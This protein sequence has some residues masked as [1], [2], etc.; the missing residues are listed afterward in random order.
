MRL[1]QDHSTL[2]ALPLRKALAEF[3]YFDSS[4]F[5]P[6]DKINEQ[7]NEQKATRCFKML[8][9]VGIFEFLKCLVIYT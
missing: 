7:K 3:I 4:F 1:F 9:E 6:H 8:I 2:R 5:F